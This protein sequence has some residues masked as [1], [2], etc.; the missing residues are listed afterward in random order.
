[1]EFIKEDTDAYYYKVEALFPIE[2][3]NM[4]TPPFTHDEVLQ[5]ARSLTGKPSDLNHDHI[6]ML[7]G[8]EVTAAQF[9]DDC[10][11]CVCR[12]PKTS[13]LIGMIQRS[14]ELVSKLLFSA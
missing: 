8:V 3:M 9:E 4:D 2:S 1:M 10:V 6:K 7:E 13:P 5:S 14:Q 12:V 11:E